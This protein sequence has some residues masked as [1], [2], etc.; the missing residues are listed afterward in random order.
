[1][2]KKFVSF[3]L[4][5]V[6]ML[7]LSVSAHAET[8][9]PSVS[10]EEARLAIVFQG[11]ADIWDS[12]VSVAK[13]KTLHDFA[14]NEYTLAEYS[15][16]GYAVYHNSSAVVLEKAENSPS[17]Y[18][19]LSENLYYAGPTH[20]YIYDEEQG[21]YTHTITGDTLGA[22]DVSVKAEVCSEAQAELNSR[23]DT[24]LKT[25]V[26]TGTM[27]VQNSLT[28]S[29]DSYTY[30]GDHRDFFEDLTT[31]EMMGYYD[32]G[33]GGNCGYVA[34]GLVLLYYDYFHDD[35][36]IDNDTYLSSTGDAFVGEDFAKYLY[37]D[38]GKALGYG[39]S[40]NA[41]QT[42]KVMKKYLEDDRGISMSYW[43]ANMPSK[44]NV[45]SQLKLDRPVIYCDRWNNPKPSGGTVDHVV[46]VYGYDNSN[47][48]IAHFGWT[49]YTHVECTSGAFAMFVSSASSIT[50]YS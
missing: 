7:S 31:H 26:E 45:V 22:E 3:A 49:D 50:S 20:Y 25:Y 8:A 34:A 10:Q 35:D 9:A 41:T 47:H 23:A 30:V 28:R 4:A 12:D 19:G 11:V 37:T 42:A 39:N 1:M 46:V 15:P 40:L 38:I 18:S 5:S 6:F 36:F 29:S 17:P 24:Q 14:G 33:D 27:L 43:A 21:T 13:T 32:S 48:L 2:R 44:A 16:S